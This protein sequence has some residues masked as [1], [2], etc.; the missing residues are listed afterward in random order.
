MLAAPA[1]DE[2]GRFS[3]NLPGVVSAASHREDLEIPKKDGFPFHVA[4]CQKARITGLFDIR[5][6]GFDVLSG[7][8]GLL[9][10]ASP[11]RIARRAHVAQLDRAAPS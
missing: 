5:S 2:S 7:K 1:P 8:T 10:D 6:P 9:P 4:C 11:A 3:A